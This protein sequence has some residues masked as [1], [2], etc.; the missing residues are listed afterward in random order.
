[1][2]MVRFLYML[3]PCALLLGWVI[4]RDSLACSAVFALMLPVVGLIAL[5]MLEVALM[6]RRAMVGM[7]L[8]GGSWLSR[9]L[10]R[11]VLLSIWQVIKA[12]FFTF[13]LF[14]A[15]LDWQAWFWMLLLADALLV[16]VLNQRLLAL[17]Q[18]QVKA[19]QEGII[20]RQIL[21]T[22]NTLLLALLLASGQMFESQPDYKNLSWQDTAIHAA[23]KEQLQCELLAPLVRV[24][25]MQQALAGRFVRRGLETVEH[26]WGRVV[27]WLLFFFWSGLS[28][29]AWSRML[30]GTLI[31]RLDM[32]RMTRHSCR[33]E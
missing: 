12:T 1:M 20:A 27:G 21:V 33:H 32:D 8:H 30:L 2:P 14:M 16:L 4:W 15:V 26:S 22:A 7:Y 11:K 13:V 17:L 31:S 25:A 6:R 3:L 24:Q 19:A 9:L 10:C 5:N 18:T 23:Q 29:W 28:L